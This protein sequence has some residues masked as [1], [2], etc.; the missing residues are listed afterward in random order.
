MHYAPSCH[1][2]C[3]GPCLCLVHYSRSLPVPKLTPLYLWISVRE[4]LPQKVFP[5]ML[6][7]D[8]LKTNRSPKYFHYTLNLSHVAYAAVCN[9][10]CMTANPRRKGCCWSLI[11]TQ[12]QGQRKEPSQR[13]GSVLFVEWLSEGTEWP[14]WI[15]SH[16]FKALWCFPEMKYVY[17][18]FCAHN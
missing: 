6:L 5:D 8:S 15:P 4:S 17:F 11:T 13:R 3:L 18:L 7:P 12:T 16:L 1:R 10:I 2:L 9:Y 14:R